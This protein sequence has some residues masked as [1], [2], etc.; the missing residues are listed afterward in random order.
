MKAYLLGLLAADGSVSKAG[1]LKLELHQKDRCLGELARDRI[2][3]AARTSDY[4]T[5]TSTR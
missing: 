5:R 1:Q 2:E 3:Q 4:F